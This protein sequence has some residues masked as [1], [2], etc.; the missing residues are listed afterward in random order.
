M[1]EVWKRLKDFDGKYMVSN[2]GRIKGCVGQILKPT[3]GGCGYLQVGLYSA[4]GQKK[5]RLHRLIASCFVCNPENK[6]YV[7]H[8]NGDKID[9]RIQN[10]EW[11]TPKENVTHANAIGLRE[12]VK[13]EKHFASKLLDEEREA[14]KIMWMTDNYKQNKLA[15]MFNISQQSVSRIVKE[16]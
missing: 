5:F 12:Y 8:K 10:L 9:N 15:T 13:G 4:G 6:P 1:I 11:V 16:I 3:L 14:L 7:N 2:K